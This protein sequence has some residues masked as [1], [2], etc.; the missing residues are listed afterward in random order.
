M[1]FV[2]KCHEIPRAESDW[3]H[4]ICPPYFIVACVF[5]MKY[6]RRSEAEIE[7]PEAQVRPRDEREHPEF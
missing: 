3:V 4:R 7:R 5:P 1:D 6:L 2:A